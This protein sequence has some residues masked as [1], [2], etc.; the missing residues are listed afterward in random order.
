MAPSI[1]T[2]LVLVLGTSILLIRACRP[3]GPPQS[4]C[5]HECHSYLD[6]WSKHTATYLNV[7]ATLRYLTNDWIDFRRTT[8]NNLDFSILPI[9]T[10][11]QGNACYGIRNQTRGCAHNYIVGDR[12]LSCTWTYECDY[13]K[14]RIPQYLWM[15]QC[16]TTTSETVH[17]PVPVLTR[18]DSCN[19]QSTWQLTIEELPVACACKIQ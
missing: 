6:A 10:A 2:A 11:W 19:P 1:L 14:N 12:Q 13:N 5:Q 8:G 15:A 9:G 4:N 18:Q 16:N 3:T 7:N 17:Y